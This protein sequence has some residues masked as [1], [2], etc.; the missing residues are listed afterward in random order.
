MLEGEIQSLVPEKGFGF[1]KPAAGGADVFFHVSAIDAPFESLTV[2]LRVQYELDSQ[3]EKPRA[4]VVRTGAAS[5]K[6]GVAP[7]KT[8]PSRKGQT[9]PNRRTPDRRVADRRV[10]D[11]PEFE[12]GFVTKLHRKKFRGFISSIKHGP[13]F[14]FAAQSVTGDKRYS[15][16]EIGDYVQFLVAEPDP[17]EPQQPVAKAVQV[18]ERE[19]KIPNEKRLGRHPNARKKKPTW[20]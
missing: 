18:V 3:A 7:S 11:R 13:E 8:R 17:D 12:H 5:A 16:L 19:V 1:I 14:V 20:R 9:S 6:V 4:Q 2:G 15:R 10:A